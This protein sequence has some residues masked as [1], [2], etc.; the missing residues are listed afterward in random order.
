MAR[1]RP[2]AGKTLR[3]TNPV[4]ADLDANATYVF[5]APGSEPRSRSPIW[6]ECHRLRPQNCVEVQDVTPTEIRVRRGAGTS[7]TVPLNDEVGLGTITSGSACVYLDISGLPHHAWAPLLRL[8]FKTVP[9]VKAVYVEPAEYRKHP[10]PTSKTEFDLSESFRGIEP[11]PGFAKLAGPADEKDAILVAMLGFEGRRASHLALGLDPVP[12]AYAVVGV[13]GFRIE[14]PQI[15][16]A[17][18]EQFLIECQAYP[19]VRFAAASCPFEAYQAL[20]GIRRDAGDKYMYVAPIGTKPHALGAVCFALKNHAGTELMYDNPVK[21]S[22]R[23]AG[24]GTLHVYTL[25][26]SHVAP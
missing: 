26:P 25:K 21:R 17:S 6:D 22:G 13:P 24:C 5:S 4:L 3:L 10:N 8:A 23:T 7:M 1:I 20:D 14:Y 18:N 12:K 16:Y 15:A 11:L 2:S 19:N 9:V